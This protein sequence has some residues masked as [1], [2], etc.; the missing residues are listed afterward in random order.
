M[1]LINATGTYSMGPRFNAFQSLNP[2]GG[3]QWALGGRGRGGVG[4]VR[5]GG[6]AEGCVQGLFGVNGS[7]QYLITSSTFRMFSS[8]RFEEKKKK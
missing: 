4:G 2:I 7:V 1:K 6:E 3:F 5:G 8:K